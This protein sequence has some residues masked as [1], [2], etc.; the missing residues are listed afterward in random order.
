MWIWGR[1]ENFYW[2]DNFTRRLFCRI[3]ENN[4]RKNLQENR[5]NFFSIFSRL[6]CN[7]L[8]KVNYCEINIEKIWIIVVNVSDRK[9]NKLLI[10]I[11]W[12]IVAEI[13][14]TW[15][16]FIG[17]FEDEMLFLWCCRKILVF[18][19]LAFLSTSTSSLKF[20]KVL[21]IKQK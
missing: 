5:G 18:P 6:S 20:F 15:E 2:N 17:N 12:I 13:V 21:L 19:Y 8:V 16:L 11:L 1:K 14:I 3:Y 4:L 9:I 7:R 10:F